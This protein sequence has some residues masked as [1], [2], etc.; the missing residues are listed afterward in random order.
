[1]VL[2]RKAWTKH[3]NQFWMIFNE[4]MTIRDPNN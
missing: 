1:M 2:Y 4:I 3:S